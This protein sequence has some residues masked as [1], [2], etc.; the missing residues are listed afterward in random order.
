MSQVSLPDLEGVLASPPPQVDLSRVAGL[1]PTT[2]WPFWLAALGPGL[3]PDIGFQ[4]KPLRV[5]PPP[6]RLPLPGP[7]PGLFLWQCWCKSGRAQEETS[8]FFLA[9]MACGELGKRDSRSTPGRSGQS[10]GKGYRAG[11]EG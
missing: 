2:D 9:F 3:D 6:S 4:V 5:R 7:T 1:P 11:E 10:L 8:H